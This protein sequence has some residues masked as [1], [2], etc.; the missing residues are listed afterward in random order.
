[1]ENDFVPTYHQPLCRPIDIH[2]D[3]LGTAIGLGI[4]LGLGLG[5]GQC[6]HTIIDDVS[7]FKYYLFR[8]GRARQ[9]FK[10]GVTLVGRVPERLISYHYITVLI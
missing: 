9:M 10:L 3:L 1:M 4:C 8:Q 5:L 2:C 7:L 6:K